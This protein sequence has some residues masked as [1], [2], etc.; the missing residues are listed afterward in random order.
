MSKFW[1]LVSFAQKLTTDT[2]G[3]PSADIS[4]LCS[5]SIGDFLTSIRP[6]MSASQLLGLQGPQ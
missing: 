6:Q 4:S 2:V 5:E 3:K 1:S